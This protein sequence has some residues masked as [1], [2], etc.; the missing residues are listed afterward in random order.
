MEKDPWRSTSPRQLF[1]QLACSGNMSTLYSNCIQERV[2]AAPDVILLLC[3]LDGL[4]V[5]LWLWMDLA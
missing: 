1:V 2:R 5:A 3:H 4:P